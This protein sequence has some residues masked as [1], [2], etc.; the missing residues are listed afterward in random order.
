MLYL[1]LFPPTSREKY[2][3]NTLAI[4]SVHDR[5]STPISA[6]P[7]GVS[8]DSEACDSKECTVVGHR[9]LHLGMRQRVATCI[10][11]GLVM[12]DL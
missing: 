11:G 8:P 9:Y 12:C 2:L 10:L 5:N 1:Y 6:H 3:V 4:I 7:E